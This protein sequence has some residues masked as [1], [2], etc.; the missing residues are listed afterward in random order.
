MDIDRL[1]TQLAEINVQLTEAEQKR[2]LAEHNVRTLQRRLEA[3]EHEVISLKEEISKQMTMNHELK[4]NNAALN[5][6]LEST[7]IY[8]QSLAAERSNLEG[9]VSALQRD[10]NLTSSMMH[11]QC[12][13]LAT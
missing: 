3:A 6:R 10:Q 2:A 7:S 4:A 9:Q 5:K 13:R 1:R 12:R 11:R 8:C